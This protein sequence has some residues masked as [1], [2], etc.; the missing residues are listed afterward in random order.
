MPTLIKTNLPTIMKVVEQKL[1]NSPSPTT[2]M[3]GGPNIVNDISNVYW[4]LPGRGD[5]VPGKTGQRDIILDQ[6]PSTPLNVEGDGRFARES[7]GISVYL[8]T[9]L[10][11]DRPG[12]LKDWQIQDAALLDAMKNALYDFLPMDAM[13]NMLTIFGLVCDNNAAPTGRGKETW[14]EHVQ[15]YRFEYDPNVDGLN[16]LG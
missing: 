15:T 11:S 12:T 5:P 8:R 14:G 10:A 1:L 16:P 13:S 6:H 3:G 9:T 7:S 2:V 4:T